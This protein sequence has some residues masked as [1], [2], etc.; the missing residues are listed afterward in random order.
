MATTDWIQEDP[1]VVRTRAS[2]SHQQG[3]GAW[4]WDSDPLPESTWGVVFD[5]ATEGEENGSS[6]LRVTPDP[7]T[8]QWGIEH[9]DDPHWLTRTA[10]QRR[11][12]VE[13]PVDHTYDVRISS[14]ESNSH[15]ADY[16]D[17]GFYGDVTAAAAELVPPGATVVSVEFE[18]TEGSGGYAVGTWTDRVAELEVEAGPPGSL[19]FTTP[20]GIAGVPISGDYDPV[21]VRWAQLP[22][23]S[24]SLIVGGGVWAF[25]Y[26]TETETGKTSPHALRRLTSSAMAGLS[27][28]LITAPTQGTYQVDI[29]DADWLTMSVPCRQETALGYMPSRFSALAVMPQWFGENAGDINVFVFPAGEDKAVEA[30]GKIHMEALWTPPRYR[31]HYIENATRPR[32]R[33]WPDTRTRVWPPSSAVPHRIDGHL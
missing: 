8:V 10:A 32:Q 16:V 26:A 19:R 9:P 31:V 30:F 12:A 3:R 6:T 21:Q 25:H 2:V 15:L 17:A 4:I 33:I 14:M 29:S 22:E 5:D 23:G 18:P 7:S 27:E 11:W 28:E 1:R 13:H 24:D 20:P